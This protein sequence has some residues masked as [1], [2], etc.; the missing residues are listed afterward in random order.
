MKAQV[1][2]YINNRFVGCAIRYPIKNDIYHLDL[3]VIKRTFNMIPI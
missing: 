3:G 1:L 2:N